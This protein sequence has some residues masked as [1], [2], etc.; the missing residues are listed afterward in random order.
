MNYAY[1]IRR[2]AEAAPRAALPAVASALWKAF[3]EGHLS[4]A[5]AE[6]LSGLIEARQA[7]LGQGVTPE[8][9]TASAEPRRGRRGSRPRTDASMARRRRWAASGRLPPGLAARFTLAEQAVLSLVAAETARQ[10]DCRL[11]VGHLAA[12][13][14]VAE[15]TVRNAVREARKLGMVTVEERRVAGFRNDTNVVRIVSVEWTAWLRLARSSP[16]A[17]AAPGL[18]LQKGG[19]KSAKHTSTDVLYPVNSGAR[20]PQ[21]GTRQAVGDPANKARSGV[22]ERSC[23]RRWC[24]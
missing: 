2:Q 11:A 20:K 7:A 6:A 18:P 14:G 22:R 10:G 8:P 16:L 24:I 5:E 15:T 19:C 12:I 17:S 1:E 13:V 23:P 4:E 9:S 3:G 21:K